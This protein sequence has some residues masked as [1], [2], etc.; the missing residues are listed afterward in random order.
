[1]TLPVTLP[2][3]HGDPGAWT[4]WTAP[5]Y[6]TGR[7]RFKRSLSSLSFVVAALLVAS[8]CS[9]QAEGERCSKDNG[10]TD[11]ASGLSCKLLLEL[12]VTGDRATAGVCCPLNGPATSE[13][14]VA[15]QR[16]VP[17]GGGG[18][19]TGSTGGSTSA[20]GSGGSVPDASTGT[21]RDASAAH[22]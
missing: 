4:A 11:C 9:D 18:R 3:T 7:M 14:C 21:L 1:M 10:D 17:D 8:A 5:C 12:G 19:S 22:D 6:L 2:V 15:Q 20:G 16:E 13:A